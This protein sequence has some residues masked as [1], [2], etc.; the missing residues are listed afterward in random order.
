MPRHD[1]SPQS[2][3][4]ASET[5]RQARRGRVIPTV[6]V[7]VLCGHAGIVAFT[8][9]T[10]LSDPSVASEPE[11]YTKALKWDQTAQLREQSA[12]LGWTAKAEL[13]PATSE[14][15]S[16]VRVSLRDANNVP[17]DG[18]DVNVECFANVRSSDRHTLTLGRISA[19]E[20]AA[21]LTMGH[22]G[23]WVVRVRAQA[24]GS[25]FVHELEAMSPAGAE[26]NTKRVTP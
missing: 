10:A 13:E 4:V 19:G 6:I 26:S 15:T 23:W 18:A 14:H 5:H 25:T 2:N 12:R 9:S 24:G 17:I 20:Y 7:A 21:P 8:V 1:S 11:Y 3:S 22:P 16:R